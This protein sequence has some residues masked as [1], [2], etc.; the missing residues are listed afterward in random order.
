MS[1]E[2]LMKML[3]AKTKAMIIINEC[4]AD[5]MP[6]F[7]L[8]QVLAE[9]VADEVEKKTV[10]DLVEA[11]MLAS[12]YERDH[13]EMFLNRLLMPADQ[14]AAEKLIRTGR[15]LKR[16][17]IKPV[18]TE[19]PILPYAP[20]AQ[21][22]GQRSPS[23]RLVDPRKSSNTRLLGGN[24]AGQA[25]PAV[26]P[27]QPR[28]IQES[29]NTLLLSR[30]SVMGTGSSVRPMILVADDD[31]RARLIARIRLE[32]AG[33][34]VVEAINGSDAWERISQDKGDM[35]LAVIDMKMPGM[36]GIE[37]LT[38]MS[39]KKIQLPII[40]CSA[41]GEFKKEPT[42]ASNPRLRYLIKPIQTE[43]MMAAV[44]E[45]LGLG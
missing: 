37:I 14:A 38:Q 3:S 9:L 24:V 8:R 30:E 44:R 7:Q 25:N 45:L 16:P 35:V 4:E 23:G 41:Y 18:E 20:K 22:Q 36:H 2:S 19:I 10:V 32:E 43:A 39:L 5:R 42:V 33:F 12:G 34:M 21:A 27:V 11:E 29:R 40:V 1:I 26:I 13:V 28:P 6:M 17:C 15:N 31:R